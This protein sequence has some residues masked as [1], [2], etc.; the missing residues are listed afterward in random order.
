MKD[1]ILLFTFPL[2]MFVPEAGFFFGFMPEWLDTLL[3]MTTIIVVPVVVV[4]VFVAMGGK[5][6]RLIWYII[7]LQPLRRW[8]TRRKLQEQLEYYRDMPAGGDL[9]I[10]NAVMN[11][12]SSSPIA[13]YQGLFGAL[14]LRLI[15]KGALVLENKA[16]IYGSEPHLVLSI[17]KRPQTRENELEMEFLSMLVS[18]SGNDGILQPRELQQYLRNSKKKPS[19]FQSLETLSKEEKDIASDPDTARQVLGLR[20]FLLEFTLIGIRDIKE[21]PLWKEY[22][23]YATL[24]GIADQ[25]SRNFGEVYSDYFNANKLALTELNIVG[26]NALVNYTNAVASGMK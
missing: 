16:T 22:L 2:L 21:M 8:L 6:F 13:D 12:L 11:A 7:S 23:I 3:S 24:F 17:G 19:F 26:N 18:A 20:K 9:K 10:A 14:I 1:I 4:L 15:E 25:V 5:T